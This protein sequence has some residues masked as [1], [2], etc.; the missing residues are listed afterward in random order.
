MALSAELQN[1]P[2]Q[3]KQHDRIETIGIQACL[4]QLL[5][6]LLCNLLRDQPIDNSEDVN[7]T[8]G[9]RSTALLIIVVFGST[10]I[11]FTFTIRATIQGSQTYDGAVGCI[12]RLCGDRCGK[13]EKRKQKIPR[14]VVVP[15][16]DMHVYAALKLR[17]NVHNALNKKLDKK[18]AAAAAGGGDTTSKP[19]SSIIRI[20]EKIQRNSTNHRNSAVQVIQKRHIQRRN[21][22]QAK[23]KARNI[24]KQ[25]NALQNCK[26]FSQ[27]DEL[28]R[29]VIIDQMELETKDAGTEICKQGDVA[30]ILYLLLAGSCIVFVNEKKVATLN[31][32]YQVFGEGALFPNKDGIAIRSGTVIAAENV[33]LLCLSKVKFEQLLDSGTLDNECMAKLEH[34]AQQRVAEDARRQVLEKEKG[35]VAEDARRQVLEKEKGEMKLTEPENEGGMKLTEPPLNENKIEKVLEEI[36]KLMEHKIKSSKILR[37]I[38]SK[39]NKNGKDGVDQLDRVNFE[40]II[41]KALEMKKMGSIISNDE[42][43][44]DI[45]ISACGDDGTKDMIQFDCMEVWLGSKKMKM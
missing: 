11:F 13:K 22:L 38:Y 7:N 21:I 3:D 4:L 26:V 23:V 41:S 25:S 20:A 15:A 19:N 12:A 30:D 42:V 27:V 9:M 36:R 39:F 16:Q 35:R 37:K 8:L 45:W 24:A 5:V 32:K 18:K 2:Y 1:L 6:A 33:Q 43:W 31:K 29:A 44:D 28:S 34:I 40:A 17:Q 10:F 14:S